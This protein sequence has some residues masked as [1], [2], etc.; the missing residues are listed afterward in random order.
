MPAAE[1]FV[2]ATIALAVVGWAGA[3]VLRS[4]V[5]WAAAAGLALV[6]SATAF[7]TFYGGSHAVARRETMR[8]TAAMTG[9]DFPGG[10]YVNY[11]FLAVWTL[12]AGW[13]L[14]SPRSY[15][16]RPRVLSL[17]IRGFIFFIILN[18]AVIFADGWAR[19][20]GS[21]AVAAVLGTWVFQC[22]LHG[23]RTR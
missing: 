7:M 6:H 1:L 11:V 15:H 14:L 20:I 18:G 13:W 21:A 2:F 5:L 12:D 4:R 8:Q 19:V 16:Q 17:A 23:P 10:I 22:Q 9:I 3:E